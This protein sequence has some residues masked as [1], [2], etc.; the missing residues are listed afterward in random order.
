MLSRYSAHRLSRGWDAHSSGSTTGA[1]LRLRTQSKQQD[2]CG[3][4]ALR[5]SLL[6]RQL[7]GEPSHAGAPLL[8]PGSYPSASCAG[9]CPFWPPRTEGCPRSDTT[10]DRGGQGQAQ[11]GTGF[12]LGAVYLSPCCSHLTVRPLRLP[13]LSVLLE[14]CL[15]VLSGDKQVVL[16]IQQGHPRS[17]TVSCELICVNPKNT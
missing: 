9:P 8:L 12:I 1:G 16:L 11:A 2:S 13:L 7:P 6:Q 3:R 17:Y 15:L 10:N 14:Q 4:P 5:A